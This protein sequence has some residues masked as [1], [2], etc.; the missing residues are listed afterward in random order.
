MMLVEN[1]FNIGQIVF[2]KTDKEQLPRMVTSL[3]V[4]PNGIVYRLSAGTQDTE[5]YEME[6]SEEANILEKID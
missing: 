5:N 1:K 6:L 3:N 2:I 4:N